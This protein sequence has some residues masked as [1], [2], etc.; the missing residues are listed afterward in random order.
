M[1]GNLQALIRLLSK[2]FKPAGTALPNE[3][4]IQKENGNQYLYVVLNGNN[5]VEKLDLDHQR[6][7][8]DQSVRGCPVWNCQGKL[9]NL[10]FQLGGLRSRFKRSQCCRGFPWGSAKVDPQNGATREGNGVG[11]RTPKR[12]KSSRDI[13]VGLHPND[14][15]SSPNEKFI[16]VSNA[17]SDA[18]NS[19]ST[20]TDENN[21]N[22]FGCD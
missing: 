8:L 5:T 22:H 13:L 16:Y 10:C 6:K 20:E 11:T 1:A 15:I 21:R 12:V 18:I 7:N 19:I 2:P 3:V 9:E 17:N 4:L 14:L